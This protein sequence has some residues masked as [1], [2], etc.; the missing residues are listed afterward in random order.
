VCTAKEGRYNRQNIKLHPNGMGLCEDLAI[1]SDKSL[2]LPSVLRTMGHTRVP[3]LS[4]PRALYIPICV[5][6]FLFIS[7]MNARNQLALIT[8]PHDTVA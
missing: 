2:S 1:S 3:H 5:P 8:H 7:S 4:S 6:S